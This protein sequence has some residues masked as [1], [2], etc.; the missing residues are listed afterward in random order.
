MQIRIAKLIANSGFCSRREAEKLIEEGKVKVNGEVLKTPAFLA[1]YQDSVI[2]KGKKLNL[3][4]EIDSQVILFNKPR[5]Y[6]CTKKDEKGRKTIYDLLPDK[7]KKF[8]YVGR[9]DLNS[10]GLLLLT[11]DPKIKRTLELPENKIERVYKVKVYGLVE[12]D[13]YEQV[14]KGIRFF[15]KELGRKVTYQAQVRK[16]EEEKEESTKTRYY[17]NETPLNN[18]VTARNTW[19]EFRLHE[20]KNREIR[21]ICEHFE[22]QVAR[23]RRVSFYKFKLRDLKSGGYEKLGHAQADDLRNLSYN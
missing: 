9:L 8:H 19:L 5:G 6:T 12:N 14:N 4:P 3:K 22:L 10:E 2:V 13:F 21:N 1:S 17:K 18:L 11:N 15:D 23:L 7:F 16:I 20:G